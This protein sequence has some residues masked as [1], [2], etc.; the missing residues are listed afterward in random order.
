MITK[1][2]IALCAFSLAVAF[3]SSSK[4]KRHYIPIVPTKNNQ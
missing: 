2:I 4:G 3:L 1:K